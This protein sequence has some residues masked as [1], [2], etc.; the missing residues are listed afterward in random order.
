[1]DAPANPLTDNLYVTLA[2]ALIVVFYAAR[3]YNTPETNRLSTT[4]SLFFLAGVG[5]VAASLAWLC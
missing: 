4:R 2:C 1:M 5:Y 3:R